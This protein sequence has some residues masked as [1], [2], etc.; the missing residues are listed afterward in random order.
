[1]TDGKPDYSMDPTTCICGRHAISV[2]VQQYSQ[3][4]QY[5]CRECLLVAE[6]IKLIVADPKRLS[7]YESMAIEGGVNAVGE[8]LSGLGK[9]DLST[10]DELEQ[11]K[12]VEVAHMGCADELR[13]LIKD[14]EAP[15]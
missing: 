12:L 13:R 8:Y 5:L 6:D 9:Y 4:I 1:M 10:F 11:R 14:G 2:G 7:I 3:P 15:F